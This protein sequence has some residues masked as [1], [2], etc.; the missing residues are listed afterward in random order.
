MMAEAMPEY[1]K[2]LPK[3]S[4]LNFMVKLISYFDS[5]AKTMISRSWNY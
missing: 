2:K 3:K 5:S 1:A 4:Y